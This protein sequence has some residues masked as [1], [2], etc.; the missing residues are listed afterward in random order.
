M[1]YRIKTKGVLDQSWSDWLGNAKMNSN[2]VEDSPTITTLMVG[3][4]DQS[5]LFGILGSIRD[6]NLALITVTSDDEEIEL[7]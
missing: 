4:A 7:K 2:Q 1:I 5:A 3:A 6:L